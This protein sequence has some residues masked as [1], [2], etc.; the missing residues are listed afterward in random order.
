MKKIAYK[1]CLLILIF[2]LISSVSVTAYAMGS[3]I[4]KLTIGSSDYEEVTS[5]ENSI[6]L[7][8]KNFIHDML[9]DKKPIELLIDFEAAKKM[10]V[11]TDIFSLKTSSADIVQEALDTGN[12]M[13]L[14]PVVIGSNRYNVNIEKGLPLNESIAHLLNDEEI[15]QIKENEGKWSISAIEL[16]EEGSR[17][18]DEIINDTL[19]S[20]SY[21]KE[22]ANISI[23]GGIKH[24]RQP[25]AL[26]ISGNEVELLIPLHGLTVDGTEAQINKVKPVLAGIEDEV[27]LYN[28]LMQAANSMEKT[29]EVRWGTGLGYIKLDSEILNTDFYNHSISASIFFMTILLLLAL[30]AVYLVKRRKKT[31]SERNI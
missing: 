8:L 18:Y 29:S 25:V 26:I 9:G 23:C 12:Y 22:I 14:L 6:V 10:Y 4:E 24:L 20:I 15:R 2:L 5:L 27:Y 16:C 30:L 1:C 19:N 7:M 17:D 28:S 13:W 31:A 3:Q 11:G 21:H